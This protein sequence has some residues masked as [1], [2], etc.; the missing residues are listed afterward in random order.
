MQEWCSGNTED[1]LTKI[2]G[3]ESTV[4]V[5]QHR[6][7]GVGRPWEVGVQEQWGASWPPFCS[8]LRL[9]SMATM[10]DGRCKRHGVQMGVEVGLR[11]GGGT[12]KPPPQPAF[13][14]PSLGPLYLYFPK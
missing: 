14:L 7:S 12:R 8:P 11:T 2:C 9:T 4:Y 5:D 13:Q 6:G 10:K 1:L 3:L